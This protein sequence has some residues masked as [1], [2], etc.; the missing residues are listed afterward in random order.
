MNI[1]SLFALVFFGTLVG[2]SSCTNKKS[3]KS[4]YYWRS[5]YALDKTEQE[6]LGKTNK[7]YLKVCDVRLDNNDNP[8]PIAVML[9]KNDP[10]TRIQYTPVVFI[11]KDIFISHQD[12]VKLGKLSNLAKNILSLITSSWSH[13]QLSFDEIQID[14]DWT[15]KSKK[16][17]FIFLKELKRQSAKKVTATLR[18][19]Q[20]KNY[21]IT[22]VPP[23]DEGV[24]MA[25]NMGNISNPK[26]KNSI[27]SMKVLKR[28]IHSNSSF[29]LP[30]KLALPIFSWKL[31]YREGQFKGIVSR[32]SDS[33]LNFNF[34]T[35]D[36]I[37]YHCKT[38]FVS[39][40]FSFERGDILRVERVGAED[41]EKA[42]KLIRSRMSLINETIYFDLS[43]KNLKNYE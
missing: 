39:N 36:S 1:R 40:D 41:L 20:I 6:A 12:N 19:D 11:D 16:G 34:S 30:S 7:L 10:I 13:N 29:P 42:E 21:K 8:E 33:V 38:T 25:Y 32:L 18:L 15:P 23:V 17:Y 4:Y 28:Y 31:L 5:S 9:W 43:S 2:A 26:A 3:E 22:G 24:V 35:A 37:F 14:C 27:L